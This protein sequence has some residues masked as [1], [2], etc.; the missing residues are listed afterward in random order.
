MCK[1]KE[2]GSPLVEPSQLLTKFNKKLKLMHHN[3]KGWGFS[4][5]GKL[6]N[7]RRDFQIEISNLESLE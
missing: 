6:K 4:H 5:E 1:H 7:E 2:Y 3:F